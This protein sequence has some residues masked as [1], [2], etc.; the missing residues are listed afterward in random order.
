MIWP[1]KNLKSKYEDKFYIEIQRHGDQNEVGFEKDMVDI[2][3]E[4]ES[5]RGKKKK[6]FRVYLYTL[7]RNLQ[8][9]LEEKKE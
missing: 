9:G 2:P 4:R 5:E 8:K 1:L 3:P 6:A 7:N